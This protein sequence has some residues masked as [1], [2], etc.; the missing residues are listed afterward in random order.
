[1]ESCFKFYPMRTK[2]VLF[3]SIIVLCACGNANAQR[4]IDV[5]AGADIVS[6][7]VSRGNY[8]SGASIQP[9]MAASLAGFTLGTW[10]S[11][12]LGGNE[13]KE[14]NLLLHYSVKGF[15]VGLTDYWWE[16]EK[17]YKYFQYAKGK[18]AHR[19][20]ANLAYRLPFEKFPL[21]I[22]WNTIFAGN[23]YN[24]QG[25][26]C[27]STYVEM[28]YPFSAGKVDMN[29]FLGVVPWNSP[30]VLSGG[31]DGFAVCNV[32][33]SAQ[34]A[35]RC[36]DNFSIP[37]FTRLIFNPVKEDIHLVFGVAFAFGN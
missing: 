23:D 6:A 32:G 34:R 3:V 17:V 24:A 11:S 30:S 1:M 20:E 10:G 31:N 36:S 19:W 27:Y 26:R 5:S 21:S 29:V 13:R 37:L 8:D 22:A 28:K 16:G 18:T 15:T 25:E 9:A 14:V 33:I 35:I 2:I 12:D 7:Y 4:K